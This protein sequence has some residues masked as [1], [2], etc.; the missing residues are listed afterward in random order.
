MLIYSHGFGRLQGLHKATRL[1]EI[2]QY[3]FSSCTAVV[4]TGELLQFINFGGLGQ[5][6]N[7]GLGVFMK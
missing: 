7:Y 6:K 1:V 3:H 2:L 5:F 4:S